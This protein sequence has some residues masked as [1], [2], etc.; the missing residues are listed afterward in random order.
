MNKLDVEAVGWKF[1]ALMT[2]IFAPPSIWATWAIT[3]DSAPLIERLML[4]G[5]FGALL[6]AIAAWVVNE[7]LH[8]RN[9]RQHEAE[10]KAL[11]KERKHKKK[12]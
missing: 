4:G 12:H 9:V 5:A 1:F 6:A 10:K 3:N 2:V 8:R 11:K 7:M